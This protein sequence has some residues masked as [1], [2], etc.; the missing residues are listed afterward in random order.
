MQDNLFGMND[1]VTKIKNIDIEKMQNDIKKMSDNIGKATDKFLE[2]ANKITDL[3]DNPLAL[4]GVAL[5]GLPGKIRLL[6]AAFNLTATLL[7]MGAKGK[8]LKGAKG[9]AGLLAAGTSAAA[10]KEFGYSDKDIKEGT[11]QYEA[12]KKIQGTPNNPA[13]NNAGMDGKGP[14]QP[15]TPQTSKFNVVDGVFMSKTDKPLSG[16]ALDS[17]V[18]KYNA[19]IDAGT[20]TGPKLD[21]D[22]VK[23][24]QAAFRK[25]QSAKTAAALDKSAMDRKGSGGGIDFGKG[26]GTKGGKLGKEIVKKNKAKIAKLVGQQLVK[27]GLKGVPI[28]GAALGVAFAGWSLIRG[29]WTTASLEGSSI[30]LPSISGTAVDIGAVATAVFFN[31]MGLPYNP[32]NEDHN[33]IMKELGAEVKKQVEEALS[34]GEG[35]DNETEATGAFA[36]YDQMSQE[37]YI[38]QYADPGYVQKYLDGFDPSTG[39]YAAGKGPGSSATATKPGTGVYRLPPQTLEALNPEFGKGITP[40]MASDVSAYLS[41]VEGAG[42]GSAAPVVYVEGSNTDASV[43]VTQGGNNAKQS[44]V[45]VMGGSFGESNGFGMTAYVQK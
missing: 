12:D 8:T 31:L 43:Q 45:Q 37:D 40:E 24:R 11:K 44:T 25:A 4:L 17:S 39:K 32:A 28:L 18:L 6:S 7:K 38:K 29:D 1:F 30:F 36:G 20:R 2:L 3:I 42:S 33:E 5:L 22:D 21:I 15:Q 23:K 34:S 14:A 16:A 9:V 13:N 35:S 26:T 27:V 10:L 19:E 41:K